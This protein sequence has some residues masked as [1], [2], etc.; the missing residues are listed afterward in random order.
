MY[1]LVNKAIHQLIVTEFGEAKW[2]EIKEEA[3][4]EEIGFISMKSYDDRITYS[5][6]YRDWETDRKST[7][8]NSSH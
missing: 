5:L 6:G 7:R 3:S 1:G 4:F 8:L 2:E